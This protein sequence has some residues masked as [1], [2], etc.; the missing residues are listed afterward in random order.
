MGTQKILDSLAEEIQPQPS[1]ATDVIKRGFG[2]NVHQSPVLRPIKYLGVFR[3]DRGISMKAIL[4]IIIVLT[5]AGIADSGYALKQH[6]SAAES[7]SC[8][9]NATVSCTAVNQSQYSQVFG[10]PVAGIGIAGYVAMG[11]LAAL[12]LAGKG[13]RRIL[14]SGMVAVSLIALAISLALTYIEV[15]VLGA[16]CP[17]CVISLTLVALI[18]A[19]AIAVAIIRGR[20]LRSAPART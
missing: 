11:A 7:S 12:M 13:P 8:D 17:L 19:L 4:A 16:V 9:F 6:Y 18:T 20:S 14:E 15:F 10:I 2:Y 5:L 3:P 1:W